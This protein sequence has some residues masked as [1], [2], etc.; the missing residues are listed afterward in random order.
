MFSLD[1]YIIVFNSAVILGEDGGVS[2][3]E[4]TSLP[5]TLMDD[6]ADRLTAV[7]ATSSTLNVTEEN[8]SSMSQPSGFILQHTQL[9]SQPSPSL[10]QPSTKITKVSTAHVLVE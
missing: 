4:L 6:L 2:G 5:E 8:V 9:N 1:V 10:K 3:G 7:E